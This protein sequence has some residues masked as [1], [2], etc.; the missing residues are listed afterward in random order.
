MPCVTKQP[1]D[2]GRLHRLFTE[3]QSA[4][5]LGY[6]WTTWTRERVHIEHIMVGR[7]RRYTEEALLR[8]QRARTVK[9]PPQRQAVPESH[10]A[11]D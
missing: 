2:I 4:Q 1:D 8:H 5:R 11:A 7:F 6:G 10:D 3:R 9:P